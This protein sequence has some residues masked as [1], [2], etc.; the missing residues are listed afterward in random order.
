MPQIRW[1]SSTVYGSTVVGP[2]TVRGVPD[3]HVRDGSEGLSPVREVGSAE[4]RP[5][6]GSRGQPPR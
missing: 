4:R 6:S 5:V 3:D 1:I 2:T